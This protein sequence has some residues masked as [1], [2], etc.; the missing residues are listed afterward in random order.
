MA[1]L[2]GALEKGDTQLRP[3][4]NDQEEPTRRDADSSK[5]A[6]QARPR[7]PE[8]VHKPVM[9]DLS[10]RF[11]ALEGSSVF[12]GSPD[13]V[14]YQLARSLQHIAAP[15]GAPIIREGDSGRSMFI[16]EEGL[17]EVI[18]RTAD[19]RQMTITV[20]NAGDSFGEDSLITDAPHT[21][22]V[23]AT[24]MTR[25]FSLDRDALEEA[26]EPSS[27]FYRRIF[28]VIEQRRVGMQRLISRAA[29][30]GTTG[31]AVIMALYSASGGSGRTTL[32]TNLA[33]ILASHHP[34]QVLLLDLALPYN[35]AALM[36]NLTP[37]TSLAN[38]T[39]AQES[40]LERLV[41]GA[42]LHH[43]GGMAVLPSALRIHEA[44]L[45]TP[46]LVS[47]VLAI[48]SRLFEY[49]IVDLGPELSEVTLSVFDHSHRLVLVTPP[50]VTAL[51]GTKEL[52]SLLP[53]ALNVPSGQT[54]VLLNHRTRYSQLARKDVELILERP[55]DVEILHDGP[56][57]EKAMLQG[58]LLALVDP[59]SAIT[60]GAACLA[61][62]MDADRERTGTQVGA[63][64]PTAELPA[65]PVPLAL[66]PGS[67]DDMPTAY[68]PRLPPELKQT[69]MVPRPPAARSA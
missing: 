58:Q 12:A 2:E 46:Q 41:L 62:I 36:A 54:T 66:P 16:V 56:R 57:P 7:P 5:R 34:E 60:R 19:G 42:I 67:T 32:A 24:R 47:R 11:L 55:L 22:T 28:K 13:H 20:L 43:N 21:V 69:M 40:S 15:D 26:V 35:Q 50:E 39:S 6:S 29:T 18:K 64:P 37:T 30:A 4:K 3:V 33:A 8:E 1:T 9:R 44:E 45:V 23:R 49:V 31:R 51:R 63:T 17:C 59:A 48:V 61:E 65:K 38:M 27:T 68:I 14:L 53:R 52:L 25:L 10:R